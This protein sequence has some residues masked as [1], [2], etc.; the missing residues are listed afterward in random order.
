MI[1][2][3]MTNLILDKMNKPTEEMIL[4]YF[5]DDTQRRY[6][7]LIDYI[8]TNF[9]AKP[10]IAYSICSGK[11]GWNIKYKKGGKAVFTLY[12]ENDCFTVL[13]VLNNEKMNL[14]DIL[15]NEFSVYMNQLYEKTT[16][17]NGTKWLMI[18][19]TSNEILQDVKN[20]ISMKM[21][22]KI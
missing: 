18:R 15:E 19:V 9:Q 8:K 2:N 13:I 12:P 7:H 5:D 10:D 16:I 20:L 22:K 11:P 21:Q 6:I 3:N 17:F 4:S 1:K 14:F